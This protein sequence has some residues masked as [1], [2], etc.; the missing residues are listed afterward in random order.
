[1]TLN[2]TVDAATAGAQGLT[3]NASGATTFNEAVGGAALASLTTDAGGTTAIN[4]GAVTTTGEQDY[5]D[6]FTIGSNTI[7]LA[8][9]K[10][11][12]NAILPAV[13]KETS[14]ESTGWCLPS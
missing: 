10:A 8:L 9:L 2:S 6:G 12:R 5:L 4:G 11:S 14:L 7:P 3:V 13:T 1:M